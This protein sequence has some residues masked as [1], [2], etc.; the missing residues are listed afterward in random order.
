MT[1]ID[2]ECDVCLMPQDECECGDIDE[3]DED[4]EIDDYEDI[5]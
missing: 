1:L 3:S 4:E 5:E 2:E